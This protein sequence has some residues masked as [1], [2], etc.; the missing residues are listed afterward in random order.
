MSLELTLIRFNTG[1][2]GTPGMLFANGDFFGHTVEDVVRKGKKVQ[3]VTA[4]PVG[5]YEV[6]VNMSPRFK[7]RMTE[8]VGVTNFTGVRLHGGN[9]HRDSEGCPLVARSKLGKQ[10]IGGVVYDK[11]FGS[12]EKEITLLVQNEMN[13]G[14]K[15]YIEIINTHNVRENMI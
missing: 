8:I 5:R 12:L 14:N 13:K 11:I 6:V 10:T 4:I 2:S 3:G 7:R 9:D 15:V 1:D